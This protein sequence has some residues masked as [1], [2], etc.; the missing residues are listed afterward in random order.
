MA[1]NIL[2]PDAFDEVPDGWCHSTEPDDFGQPSFAINGDLWPHTVAVVGGVQYTECDA[3]W[4]AA[5]LAQALV[6]VSSRSQLHVAC[7][8]TA[9]AASLV[10]RDCVRRRVPASM[11]L[12]NTAYGRAAEFRAAWRL[13]ETADR[14]VAFEPFDR[15]AG[16]VLVLARIMETRWGRGLPV[17]RVRARRG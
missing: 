16:H 13:L 7:A 15:L 6:A 11:E 2:P 10:Y 8:P 9:G 5:Q 17:V 3:D 4:I 14:V 12:L 1:S